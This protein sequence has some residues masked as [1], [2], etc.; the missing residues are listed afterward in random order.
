VDQAPTAVRPLDHRLIGSVGR[1]ARLEL[2]FAVRSGRTALV[3]AYAE[4]PFRVGRWF[5]DGDSVHMIMATTA[6]G[7]FGGDHLTQAI[8][9]EEGASV[10]LTSQSSLQAHP[11][12]SGEG[13]T[14]TSKY[15]VEDDA[16]F[17]CHWDPLIPFADADLE[18]TIS[19]RLAGGASLYWSD[20]FMSGRQARGERWQFARLAHEL[21]VTRGARLEY[22]ERY[23]IDAGSNSPTQRWGAD[24][25][26]YVGTMLVSGA[27]VAGWDAESAHRSLTQIVG[28][29]G[30]VDRL[31]NELVL[32][33]LLSTEGPPFHRA[34][35]MLNTLVGAGL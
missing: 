19:V 12:A 10:R 14:I 25:A 30:A 15:I 28:I 31:D 17:H 27:E 13:A 7:V 22:L 21:R 26:N 11:S 9:V 35:A 5:A 4:P 23:R 3:H 8:H 24:A 1:Q 29:R 18:Q 33:R 20:A 16:R 32:A 6:P 2:R 34:R